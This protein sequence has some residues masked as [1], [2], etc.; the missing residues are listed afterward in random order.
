[1]KD[2]ATRLVQ[3]LPMLALGLEDQ[4]RL[5]WPSFALVGFALEVALVAAND[6]I[7]SS[8]P[9]DE[10]GGAAA[11]E[12]TAYELG[13]G[14][15]VSVLATGLM[16]VCS[17]FFVAVAAYIVGLVGSSNSPVSGMTICSVLFT[18]AFI[19]VFGYSGDLA[20]LATLGVA[21]VGM[22]ALIDIE[23]PAEM[24]WIHGGP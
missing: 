12:E 22:A 14:F 17:F 16:V 20:I 19:A 23:Q 2:R 10:A 8:V 3:L 7:I 21:G 13:G 5:L 24:H 11:I 6:V 18:S 9:A 15:G 1:M 4:Y